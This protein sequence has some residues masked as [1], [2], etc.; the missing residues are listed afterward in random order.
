MLDV[1]VYYLHVNTTIVNR[2]EDLDLT[3]RQR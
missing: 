3:V 1:L 2:R